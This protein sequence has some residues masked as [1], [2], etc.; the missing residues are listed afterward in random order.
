MQFNPARKSTLTMLCI[1]TLLLAGSA[2]SNE[3]A[4]LVLANQTFMDVTTSPAAEKPYS[5]LN[6]AP[7]G[8]VQHYLDFLNS[9]LAVIPNYQDPLTYPIVSMFDSG[10][11]SGNPLSPE[12]QELRR[13]GNSANASRY[14]FSFDHPWRTVGT[15]SPAE[16]YATQYN[17]TIEAG[18]RDNYCLF[19][20]SNQQHGTAIAAILAGYPRTDSNGNF[21]L[22]DNSALPPGYTL[23]QN[24][25]LDPVGNT[26]GFRKGSG[27]SPYGRFG[28]GSINTILPN[29]VLAPCTGDATDPF[30]AEDIIRITGE[31]HRRIYWTDHGP[32]DF[33]TNA[34]RP[35]HTAVPTTQ[36]MIVNHSVGIAPMTP[37]ASP[38]GGADTGFGRFYYDDIA[39]A[40]D[41]LTRD[42][43]PKSW[44]STDAGRCQTLFIAGSGNDLKV[45]DYNTKRMEDSLWNPGLAKNVLTVGVSETFNVYAGEPV[46]NADDVN[47]L[48]GQNIWLGSTSSKAGSPRYISARIKPDVVVPT[49]GAWARQLAQPGASPPEPMIYS[50]ASGSSGAPPLASGT[51]QLVWVWLK[52]YHNRT[53]DPSPALLKAYIINTAQM[54]NGALTGPYDS[55]NPT[56]NTVV[57]IPNPYQGFGRV[58]LDSALDTAKRFFVDQEV[59]FSTAA[60]AS[61]RIQYSGEI[62]ETTRTLRITLVW[63]DAVSTVSTARWQELVNNL[64]LLVLVTPP[65]QAP[66]VY[67]GNNFNL[68][69]NLAY[70]QPVSYASNVTFNA[71]DPW[72]YSSNVSGNQADISNNGLKD[73]ANNVEC[74]FLPSSFPAGTKIR[75]SV[76]RATIN[77][78]A[79]DPFAATPVAVNARKQDFALVAYNFLRIIPTAAEAWELYD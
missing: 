3:S 71:N 36:T 49:A 27:V 23:P 10:V 48:N 46:A 11:D 56:S 67:L 54:L 32:A 64:D 6:P 18:I 58:N 61:D 63:T 39:R 1:A 17:S 8:K 52:Q 68:A 5:Q 77:A 38:P 55:T 41:R 34:F 79:L 69:G 45:V 21:V 44:F 66:Q 57:P 16:S 25:T 37:P 42:G 19:N 78:D 70:S 2:R 7:A 28:C 72:L 15:P 60:G 9:R 20:A 43:R 22:E 53:A 35:Q 26:S 33:V 13:L 30:R 24:A 31:M 74:V 65:S 14:V 29:W 50:T 12:M 59:V 40:Y 75:I 4:L 76:R 62:A 73:N 51:A 47:G